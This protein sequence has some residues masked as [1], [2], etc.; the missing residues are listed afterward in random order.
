MLSLQNV[1]LQKSTAASTPENV[2][3]SRSMRS[4]RYVKRIFPYCN[5]SQTRCRDPFKGRQTLPREVKCYFCD[6]LLI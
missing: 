5:R 6:I 3:R 1:G 4:G 2:V